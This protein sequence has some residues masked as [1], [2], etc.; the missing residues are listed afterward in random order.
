MYRVSHKTYFTE[1]YM[2]C[3]QQWKRLVS[4]YLIYF[5]VCRLSTHNLQ[6]FTAGWISARKVEDM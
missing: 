1:I 2:T 5:H 4:W 6:R 3:L